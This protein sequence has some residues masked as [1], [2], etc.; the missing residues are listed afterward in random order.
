[1]K[2]ITHPGMIILIGFGIMLLFMS[3]LVYQTTQHPVSMVSAHYYEDEI[4]YQKQIDAR[5]RLQGYQE[6]IVYLIQSDKIILTVPEK[7]NN[8]IDKIQIKLHHVSSPNKDIALES[9]VNEEGVYQFSMERN[10]KGDFRM[11][12]FLTGTRVSLEDQQNITL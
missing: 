6:K 4:A 2:Q 8:Q 1:M 5:A 11:N 10:I 3:Y 12:V 7:M 9:I